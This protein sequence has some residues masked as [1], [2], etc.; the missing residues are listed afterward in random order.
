MADGSVLLVEIRRGTL[1][2]V[3]P[4]GSV[5][6]VSELGGGPNGAAIG[7]D[8]AVY[9]CNNGGFHWIESPTGWRVAGKARDYV[10]GS[11]QRVDLATGLATVLYYS[12]DGRRLRG[13]NDIVFDSGG[14]FWFTDFGKSDADG[15]EHGALYY[16]LADGSHITRVIEPLLSPNGVGLSPDETMLYVSDTISSRLFAFALEAP[17]RIRGHVAAAPADSPIMRP[18]PFHTVYGPLPGYQMFDSLAVEADG[19]V[20]VGTLLNGAITIIDPA[21]AD[22][23]DAIEQIAVDDVVTS[24]ICFGG[25]DMRDAFV[26]GSVTGRLFA[27]RWPRPGLRIPFSC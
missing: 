4:D 19:R 18:L 15:H 23:P 24:N 25:T 21:R 12:C 26:T 27:A 20:C 6:V 13:P 14:G 17:G 7:P 16:A 3:T 9:V 2:R 8:G 10:T 22:A 5:S 1:S 11:I